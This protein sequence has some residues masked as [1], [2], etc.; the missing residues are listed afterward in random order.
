MNNILCGAGL[1]LAVTA[2]HAQMT[3]APW[4]PLFKGIEHAAG[5]N[6]ANATIPRL[7]VANCV[8]V[9]LADPD[10]Q[11]FASPRASNYLAES[12]ETYSMSVSNFLKQNGLKVASAANFYAASPGGGDPQSEGIQ[13]EVYGLQICTGAVVSVA[14]STAGEPRYASLLFTTNKQVFYSFN[15]RPPGTNTDGIFTA[16]TGY[17]PILSNGVNMA[18]AAA[19]SYPDPTVH[20]TQPRTILGTSEDERYLFIMVIDGRQGGYS[21]GATD[22]EAALWMLQFGG[23]NAIN[24]DGGGSASL[25]MADCAGNPKPL[26]H[27]SYVAGR[28]RERYT[29]SQFGV[30]SKASSGFI[31]DVNVVPGNTNAVV[32]WT[33]AVPASSQVE[34]GLTSDYAWQTPLDPALVTSHSV[35]L[36]ELTPGT[37]YYYRIRSA[38]ETEES[39]FVGC[40]PLRT[41]NEHG[42]EGWLFALTNT[43]RYHSNSMDATP[44][45]KTPGYDDSSWAAGPGVFW[46]DSRQPPWPDLPVSRATRMANNPNNNNYPFITYYFRTTFVFTNSPVGATLTFSNYLDDGAAYYLNGVEI[47]RAFLPPSPTQITSSTITQTVTPSYPCGGNATCPYVF[48]ISGNLIT[49]LVQGTNL[50]A[51]EAHNYVANSPDITFGAALF[52]TVPPPQP[53]PPPFISAVDVHPGETDAAITWTTRSNSTTRLEYGLTPSLG[54]FTPLDSALVTKHAVTLTNLQLLTSYFFRAISSWGANQYSVTGSFSTVPFYRGVVTLTN[55]W[56]YTENNLD[57][58]PDWKTRD[59]DDG[60][61]PSGPALLWV[62][63][64]STQNPDVQPKFTQM[65]GDPANGAYPYPTYYCRARFVLTSLEPGLSLVLSNF[66][67]DGAVFY[68]N[69]AEMQRLRMPGAPTAISNATLA[70]GQPLTDDAVSADVFRLGGIQLSNLVV[71]TNLLAVEVHNVSSASTDVT[72]GSSVGWV[73]ALASETTLSIGRAGDAICV[74]WPGAYLTLQHSSDPANPSSWSDLPGPVQSSPYCVTN[75]AGVGFYR[76]RD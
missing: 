60:A 1:L 21:D 50:V 54:T 18:Q 10:V 31:S 42:G 4:A 71:G 26:G 35:I 43:W 39:Y 65:P 47:H 41:T 27:S 67:D 28:N 49:N 59:F 70:T 45:W 20:G 7:Q 23:W 44:A 9:D 55:T 61:W 12:R 14:D 58:T 72:L 68:L 6:Y 37:S 17:Y 46:A 15:N 5:T 32:N 2:S 16:V 69:G 63:R 22:H 33:T 53:P 57:D 36:T 24:M 66:V 62:D 29:G 40:S 13:C 64:A 25:Y 76:L 38:S 11:L 8:R 52:F 74:S 3:I 34:Y 48:S 30:S 73:R 51:V 75:L 19:I 56:R